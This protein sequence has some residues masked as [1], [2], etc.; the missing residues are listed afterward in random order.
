M[1][2][3]QQLQDEAPKKK[4]YDY[5]VCHRYDSKPHSARVVDIVSR[6]VDALR[7][8]CKHIMRSNATLDFDAI[9]ADAFI[10]AAND[11]KIAEAPESVVIARFLELFKGTIVDTCFKIKCDR[12]VLAEFSNNRGVSSS[13]SPTDD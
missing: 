2:K 6:H 11:L 3:D 12:L 9:F 10:R 4:H 13:S 1:C 5:Y 7:K 8:A